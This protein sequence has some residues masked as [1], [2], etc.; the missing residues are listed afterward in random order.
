MS[1]ELLKQIMVY[2]YKRTTHLLNYC[3]AMSFMKIDAIID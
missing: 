1:R 3:K 2:V